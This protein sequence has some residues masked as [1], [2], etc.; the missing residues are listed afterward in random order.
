MRF[1]NKIA[2]VTGAAQG[3][4]ATYASRLAAEGAAVIVA[5][6]NE[7]KGQRVAESIRKSGGNAA[8]V[9]ADVSDERSCEQLAAATKST[10]GDAQLLI[11]NAAIF[12]GL[13]YEPMMTVDTKYYLKLM[14][15]NL[16]GA[17]FVTRAIAAQMIARGGGAI[18]NQSSAGA[19]YYP[20]GKL[21]SY[22]NVSK[23]AINGLTM[24]FAAEFGPLN[25][26]VNGIAP[27]PT[28]TE[29]MSQADPKFVEAVVSR[30]PLGRTCSPDE[31]A[32]AA[33]YLLSDAAAY[34][35]GQTLCVDGGMTNRA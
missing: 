32:D 2:V 13:R 28:Q 6:I 11:N 27:G 25:I 23:L 8:F 22:Y 20:R 24:A 9:R 10:F 17:F 1:K 7:E 29:A 26:R 15:V 33:L 19:Y 5:D 4:G 35:T 30:L 34:I 18:V 31:I 21:G 12:A 16:H 3:I 14:D